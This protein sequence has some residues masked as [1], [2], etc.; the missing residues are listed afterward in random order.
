MSGCGQF[1]MGLCPHDISTVGSAVRRVTSVG[2]QTLHGTTEFHPAT[3]S[4][5][6]PVS[7]PHSVRRWNLQCCHGFCQFL[8]SGVSVLLSSPEVFIMAVVFI[9]T[10]V[11]VLCSYPVFIYPTVFT[12][13]CRACALMGQPF[14]YVLKC[15]VLMH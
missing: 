3:L 12:F 14:F 9:V 11:I 4:A 5:N 2:H 7:L 15:Y 13:L 8:Q 6:L 1:A 10:T